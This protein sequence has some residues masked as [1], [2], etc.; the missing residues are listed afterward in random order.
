MRRKTKKFFVPDQRH[1]TTKL[2]HWLYRQEHFSFFNGN[3][4]N[5]PFGPILTFAAAGAVDRLDS[6]HQDPFNELKEFWNAHKDWLIG[7]FNYDL[8]NYIEK[9]NS[10]HIDRMEFPDL[11]FFVPVTL[12]FFQTDQIE[13]RSAN[14]PDIIWEEI[15]HATIEGP[16]TLYDQI[17]CD[18]SPEVYKS[19]VQR[20]RHQIVEGDFYELNYCLEYYATSARI[21]PPAIYGRLND[22]SP[23]PFS[24]FQGM[25]DHFILSASPERFLKKKGGTLIAQPIKG[26]IRRDQDPATD[27]ILRNQL[28]TN[29]KEIAENMMIVDLMRND[30]G[31][32]AIPGSVKVPELFQVY[33]YP[34]VHQMISTITCEKRKELHP[35]TA[36]RN[37]FPMGSM[38]GAPKIR[39]M[40][41]IEN[42]EVSKRGAYSGAAGFITPDGDFDFNVL[43]RS[44]FYNEK[45]H[46]LKFNVGSAI[47]F[48]ADPEY[49]YQECLLKAQ[50]ILEALNS[51]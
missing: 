43:I 50:A 25:G 32:S 3:G 31:K 16:Q 23:M 4:Y 46:L 8:K 12:I 44:L 34:Y 45:T 29:E 9:L 1:F 19:N 33:T 6:F 20:I 14:D 49:E 36:I 7:R 13:I 35:I 11:Y 51:P 10:K 48:D 47:T 42:Y 39:V 15:Q 28:K 38:T 17:L 21:Y 5:L 26:T 41:E 30:L 40:Q 37:A 22:I 18:T 2:I 24:I 27:E